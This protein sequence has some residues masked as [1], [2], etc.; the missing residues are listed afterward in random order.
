MKKICFFANSMFTPGGEQR[1]TSKV[2]NGLIEQGYDVTILIKAKEKINLEL[3]GLS[4]KINIEFLDVDYNFKLNNIIFFDKLRTLNRKT[5][6]FKFCPKIIRHFF[7][8]N[9]LLK[10]LSNFFTENK[11]DY[12]VGV[13]GDRS[14]ILSLLKS[15]LKGKLIFWNHQDINVHFKKRGSRYYQEDSFITPLFKNFDEV[16]V[17]T[18]DAKKKLDSY[19]DINCKVI[20]NCNSFDALKKVL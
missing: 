7:C 6:I 13:A 2:A 9:K 19:Y 8:S 1:I 16:V 5:G 17:L 20:A 18:N 12:V 15:N 11:F 4:N 3:F 10:Q 14:F